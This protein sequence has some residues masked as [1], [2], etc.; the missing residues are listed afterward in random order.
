[1]NYPKISIITVT[2][3]AARALHTTLA[4]IASSN[5]PAFEV[6]VVDGGSRDG[7]A[8]VVREYAW[9]IDRLVSE[10]DE[11]IYDAMNKGLALAG[12][13][14]VWF[15]NAGDTIHDPQTITRIFDDRPAGERADIY[16]GETLILSPEGTIRGLRK[17]KLPERMTWH[18]FRRGMVVCHQSIL[19]RRAI[20]PRYD[21]TYRLA[22]DVEWVLVSLRRAA[23]IV[24]THTI[25]SEFVEGGA[26]TVH[27]KTALW[28]RYDIMRRHFGTLRTWLSHAGFVL[29]ALR[30]SYRR[31]KTST[32]SSSFQR[33]T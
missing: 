12:G 27:R 18:S 14:Y 23:T 32:G 1:M 24:N 9:R 22:A 29:D 5:Y 21:R 26:S 16:Y 31:M 4:N 11:G 25:L 7:T 13:E 19:V 8:G 3:N 33:R 15:I 20:A 30:P 17:K 2:Y 10:P 6:I 28:E